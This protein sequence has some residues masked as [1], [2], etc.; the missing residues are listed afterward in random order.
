MDEKIIIPSGTK[1]GGFVFVRETKNKNDE[2]HE[3]SSDEKIID[4][5]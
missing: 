2:L 1:I 3:V 5:P 4:F